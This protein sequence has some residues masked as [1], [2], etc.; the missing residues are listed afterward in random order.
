M[1]NTIIILSICLIIT[2][3]I[4]RDN[5]IKTK[6]SNNKSYYTQ[7]INAEI[8]VE[9]LVK[10]DDFLSKL[11]KLLVKEHQNHILIQKKLSKP[12]TIMELPE[13]S[14]HIAYTL[15]KNNLHICLRNKNGTFETQFNR[16][17]FVVMHELAHII[18][19]SIGHTEEYWNNYK[20]ILKT[21]I[22]N[23]LYEYK[24]YYEEPIEFCG[25]KITSTPYIIGGKSCSMC[26]YKLLL[27]IFIGLCIIITIMDK[28]NKK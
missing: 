4:L 7:K 23:N 19:K 28:N 24:N 1:F 18:T 11:N 10:I 2:Y 8:A 20:L 3:F 16:V 27:Y 21:A 14:K 26:P 12:I 22:D 25:K 9:K 5:L 6:A 17:Y 13:K 15:N